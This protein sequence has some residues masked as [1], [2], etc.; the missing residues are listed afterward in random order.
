M[1]CF[2][3]KVIVK[4]IYKVTNDDVA[5]IINLEPNKHYIN[6][7]YGFTSTALKKWLDV[8]TH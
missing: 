5:F 7:Y 6:I 2:F 4:I 3:P 1:A 8:K